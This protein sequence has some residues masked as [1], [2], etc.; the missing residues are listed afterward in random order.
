MINSSKKFMYVI[1]R[2]DGQFYGQSGSLDKF[3]K[4]NIIDSIIINDK[5]TAHK[6]ADRL[7][8]DGFICEVLTVSFYTEINIVAPIEKE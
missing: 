7:C 4:E 6:I 1:Q 8:N 5:M 3:W 2:N